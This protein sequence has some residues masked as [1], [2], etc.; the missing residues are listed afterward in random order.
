MRLVLI[1]LLAL[2]QTPALAKCNPVDPRLAGGYELQGV[3]EVGSLIMLGLDGA[4]GYM[5]TYGAYDEEADGCWQTDDKTVTLTVRRMRVNHGNRK[6]RQKVLSVDSRGG[7]I[8][9]EDGKAVGTY[10][11]VRKF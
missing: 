10:V 7:L 11:R 6:F 9:W 1:V 4:F 3:R 8:R 5:L 2:A